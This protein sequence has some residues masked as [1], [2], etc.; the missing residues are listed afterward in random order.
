[1]NLFK[2]GRGSFWRGRDCWDIDSK[3]YP[4]RESS[5]ADK[6]I[7]NDCNGIYG[8]DENGIAYQEELCKI[9]SRGVILVGDST[10]ARFRLPEAWMNPE[11]FSKVHK[12]HKLICNIYF[13]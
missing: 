6:Y 2:A 3:I 9:P 13:V 12:L 5:D 4:G 8:V 7:D 1:M 10:C 11:L